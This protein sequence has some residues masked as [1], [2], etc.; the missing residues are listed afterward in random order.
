MV[1]T[2]RMNLRLLARSRKKARAGDLF[3]MRLPDETFLFGRVISTRAVWT[4]AEG[5]APAVLVYIYRDRSAVAEPPAEG[6]LRPSRLL[7]PPLMTNQR[8]WSMGYFQTLHSRP[9][10]AEDVLS[11]HCFR[12][13]L[14]GRYFD[15]HGGELD[16]PVEPVG[17]YGLHSFRT[18]DDQVSDAVGIPRAGDDKSSAQTEDISP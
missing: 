16:R 4:P 2:M 15:D 3:T 6:M 8:P 13:H 9:L 10:R 1:T 14:T 11:Q 5:A 7:V 18:I 17:D 12:S